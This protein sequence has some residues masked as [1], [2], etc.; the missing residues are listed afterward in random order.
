MVKRYMNHL[1]TNR[2][3]HYLTIM[4]SFRGE[5][6]TFILPVLFYTNWGRS[7]K[8]VHLM[9]LIHTGPHISLWDVLKKASPK[10]AVI[11]FQGYA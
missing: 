8:E 7:L 10:L 5:Q 11:M 2:M 9:K 3:L 6:I 4:Y 1:T